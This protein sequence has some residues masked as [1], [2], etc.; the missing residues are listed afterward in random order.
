MFNLLKA[1]K[2]NN[3]SQKVQALNDIK[4]AISKEESRFS[5]HQQHV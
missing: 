3:K 5:G 2:N 4:N 1:K